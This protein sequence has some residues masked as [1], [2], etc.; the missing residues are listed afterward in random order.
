MTHAYDKY[1]L[2]DAMRNLGEACDYAVIGCQMDIDEFYDIFV[3]CGI[4]DEFGRG[5]PKYVCGMSGIELVHE[6]VMKS[7]IKK[8]LPD[9]RAAY[10]CSREYWC[11]WI[12]AYYQ[13]YEGIAFRKIRQYIS[14]D[15]ILKLYPALHEASEE[16]AVDTINTL[17][18]LDNQPTQLQTLRRMLGYSQ[19]MLADKSGVTLRMI[20]QY[21]QRQKDIN[22]ASGK[23]LAALAR[24]LGCST[25]GLLELRKD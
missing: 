9:D 12:S 15:R 25:E 17:I 2:D 10:G 20:Q 11:G 5:S 14:M 21:E 4:A 24:T 13:W 18:D 3:A 8:D 7:G 1:Y 22:R 23:N 6:V 16:K 19:R